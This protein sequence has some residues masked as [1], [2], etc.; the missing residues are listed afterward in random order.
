MIKQKDSIS[1]LHSQAEQALKKA[2]RK[3]IEEHKKSGQP[4]AIWRNGKVVRLSAKKIS[5]EK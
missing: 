1:L 2:V 3:V 4:L 5:K